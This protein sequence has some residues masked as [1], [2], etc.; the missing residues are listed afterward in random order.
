MFFFYP[1]D[2]T[3]VL[4]TISKYAI[5]QDV[6]IKFIIMHLMHLVPII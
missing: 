4:K 5:F 6:I 3:N 2:V 1:Y